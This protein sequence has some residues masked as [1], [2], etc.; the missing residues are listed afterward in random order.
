[1]RPALTGEEIDA[2]QRPEAYPAD[3]SAA[4]GVDRVQTHI[5]EVFLTRE[6]VYK[7]RKAVDLGFVRFRD[8][9]ARNEDCLR[10][11]ELNR[12]LAPDVYLGVAPLEVGDGSVCVGPV[13]EALAGSGE[14]GPEHCV[15]MRRLPAG[16]D[17]LTL[18][19]VGML[20]PEL[21][22]RLAL[23]IA[24]FHDAQSLGRPAP[25]TAEQWLETCTQPFRDCLG[26]LSGADDATLPQPEASAVARK[27]EAFV[28]RHGDRFELR[29]RAGRAVDGHGD[30]H[31]QHVWFES[32]TSEPLVVDCLEFNAGLRRI[33]AAADVAFVAMDLAYRGRDDL[34]ERF[35]RIYARER[36]DFALYGVVDF[37]AAYRAAVRAKVAALAAADR[38]IGEAQ[39][40]AARGSA[41][42][43]LALADDLLARREPGGLVLVAG[44]VGSG[45]TTLAECLA[46]NVRGV[47]VASD[48]VRKRTAGLAPRERGEQALYT[49]AARRR[50]YEELL[51]RAR[52]V[53]TS[54]RPVLL[55]AT[56][57]RRV[58]RAEAAALARELGAEFRVIEATCAPEVA[59]ERL[60]RR[61]DEGADASD[62]GPER[63]ESS[64]SEFEAPGAEES[65]V[66]QRVEMGAE[67]WCDRVAGL[68]ATSSSSR[69]GTG[70][71]QS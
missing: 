22:D 13:A 28:R 23:R 56:W 54:G 7:F 36:D 42:R 31:L 9:D 32:D 2:L 62:A 63:L 18:L 60:A 21:L 6:R 26:V 10:E 35:L 66:W 51:V 41:A 3:A 1:M 40:E 15:V 58:E 43:H 37:F 33:D 61:A 65:G 38:S 39:R 59:R 55:D 71:P 34:A 46:G 17:A 4:D 50:V 12:R 67:D 44:T 24:S 27:V 47:V 69:S 52:A 19:G 5:S 64:L 48:R 8:R 70:A 68:F 30:L 29:R 20:A 45:K 25:F 14:E 53:V 16:R 49:D 57:A 11:V